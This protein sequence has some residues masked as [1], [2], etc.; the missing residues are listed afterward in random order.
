[1]RGLLRLFFTIR[2][3]DTDF[4]GLG[5]RY[6]RGQ[7]AGGRGTR[8]QRIT[9]VPSG[10]QLRGQ[11]DGHVDHRVCDGGTAA[12][13]MRAPQ[14]NSPVSSATAPDGSPQPAVTLNGMTAANPRMSAQPTRAESEQT[15]PAKETPGKTDPQ[16]PGSDEPEKGP[17]RARIG[18]FTP[19][20]PPR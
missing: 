20:G 18:G 9:R 4:D 11:G 12:G 13:F 6:D 19:A 5:V 10:S 2:P 8:L 7:H 3:K 17:Q 16:K 15:V 14:P 1:M